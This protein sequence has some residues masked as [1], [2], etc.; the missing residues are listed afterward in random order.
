MYSNHQTLLPQ[1]CIKLFYSHLVTF[2][3]PNVFHQ[4]SEK[5][6]KTSQILTNILAIRENEE[7]IACSEPAIKL[8]DL[9]FPAHPPLLSKTLKHLEQGQR[10]N[11]GQVC[12]KKI[13]YQERKEPR[14]SCTLTEI[15]T[16]LYTMR[17]CQI[18][19][20]FSLTHYKY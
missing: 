1:Y 3:L 2:N 19:L 7:Q 6:G 14:R 8:Q 11:L 10:P 4:Q 16:F 17:L 15:R 9:P 20:S 5:L 13:S 18:L 12:G